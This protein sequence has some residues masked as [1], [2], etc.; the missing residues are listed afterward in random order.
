MKV[1]QVISHLRS[2]LE[3]L[4]RQKNGKRFKIP[5]DIAARAV[6]A[7]PDSGLTASEFSARIGVNLASFSK[8]RR[9]V[10]PAASVPKFKKL[11]VEENPSPTRQVFRVSTAG[12][13]VVELSDLGSVA[14]LLKLISAE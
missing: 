7:F 4:P 2:E 14:K 3:A 8:W 11:V 5:D 9:I 10:A 13:I 6:A 1:D 12:G